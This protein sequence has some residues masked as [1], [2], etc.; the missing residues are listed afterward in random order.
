MILEVFSNLNGSMSLDY[1]VCVQPERCGG[2][3]SCCGRIVTKGGGEKTDDSK[4][5]QTL[6]FCLLSLLFGST[7]LSYQSFSKRVS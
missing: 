6:Y 7:G 4:S 5:G 2:Q 1:T 3:R